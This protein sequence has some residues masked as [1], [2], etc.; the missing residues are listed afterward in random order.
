MKKKIKDLTLSDLSKL[1]PSYL[2]SCPPL[3][4][5]LDD[6]DTPD[7]FLAKWG[8]EEIEVDE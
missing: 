4:Y 3:S 8:D 2:L 6:I 7:I 5:F 1:D